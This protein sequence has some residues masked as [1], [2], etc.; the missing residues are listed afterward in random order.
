MT[1]VPELCEPGNFSECRVAVA[2][3][4]IFSP[5]LLIVG[6]IGNS[7]SM[8][9]LSRQRMRQTT[10][11]VYL[12]ILA[13]VDTTVLLVGIP[14]N[15][16]YY[17]SGLD[18]KKQGAFPCKFYSWLSP[19]VTTL[20]W[21]MLPIITFERFIMVKYP[22]WA[23]NRSTKTSAVFVF[24]AL[25]AAVGLV[26]SHILIFLTTNEIRMSSNVT[27]A[28]VD[29]YVQCSSYSELY[30]TFFIKIWPAV[31]LVLFSFAPITFLITCNLFLIIELKK[32]AHR[33][34]TRRAID[35]GNIR[36]RRNVRSVTKM[37]T[38]VCIFFLIVSTP[39][40]IYHVINRY[41]FDRTSPQDFAKE[42]LFKSVVQLLMYSNNTFNFLLYTLSGNVFRKELR[43]MFERARRSVMK[44]LNRRVYPKDTTDG[45][46]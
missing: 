2:L 8:A 41:V 31:I 22:I 32:R 33:N 23:K 42:L 28:S 46:E 19:S 26:N 36:D 45:R 6:I 24:L 29:V 3:W 37:L 17:Y 10:T 39:V 11:S 18:I 30:G 14:P 25:V 1:S 5:L 35:D 15:L 12:R 21:W 34:H 38:T 27:I 40:C 4:K 43:S 9:V 20:S 13:I 7:L 44:Y 16:M